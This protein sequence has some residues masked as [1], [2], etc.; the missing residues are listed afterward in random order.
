MKYY[1]IIK[2]LLHKGMLAVSFQSNAF[3]LLIIL[4]I[5]LSAFHS[6]VNMCPGF[7][8]LGSLVKPSLG[9]L[10]AEIKEDRLRSSSSVVS[11]GLTLLRWS[12]QISLL[13]Q[14]LKESSFTGQ[15]L[16]YSFLDMWNRLAP[17]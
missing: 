7:S 15:K 11:Y 16:A 14:F 10:Q 8:L 4:K 13:T 2:G 1:V 6:V 9:Y 12:I 3:N 17:F 5:L